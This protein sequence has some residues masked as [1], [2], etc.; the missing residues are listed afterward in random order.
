VDLA[1]SLEVAHRAGHDDSA[2]DDYG[3]PVA[4]V[5][6]HRAVIARQDVYHGRYARAAAPAHTLGRLRRLEHSNLRVTVAVAH[7]YLVG[8]SVPSS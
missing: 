5:E 1:W 6:R 7:G 4:A 3:V 2:P 8:S